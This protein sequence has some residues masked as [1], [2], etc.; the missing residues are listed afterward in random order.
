MSVGSFH[1]LL[2]SAG[3]KSNFDSKGAC[4][5]IPHVCSAPRKTAGKCPGLPLAYDSVFTK[6][7]LIQPQERHVE[8]CRATWHNLH[9]PTKVK[10]GTRWA[11]DSLLLVNPSVAW[12]QQLQKSFSPCLFQGPFH[13]L[14]SHRQRAGVPHFL[15][16][17]RKAIL[18]HS[19]SM[20]P[21]ALNLHGVLYP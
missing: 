1:R 11:H 2:A 14:L 21:A 7:D 4:F 20:N 9:V 19:T 12:H 6:R 3:M 18:M 10:A 13:T 16:L 15:L 8:R 17:D 5:K